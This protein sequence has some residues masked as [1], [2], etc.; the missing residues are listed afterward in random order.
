MSNY[1]DE[2][3]PSLSSLNLNEEVSRCLLCLDAPCSK[4]C[5]A[6]TDPAKFIRSLR[7]KNDKGAI[8]T[9]RL[10]NPLGA[11]C[12]RVCP[13]EK[14]CQAGCSRSGIDKPIDI[15]RIQRYITDEEASLGVKVYQKPAKI[16]E[17]RIAIVG[18]GPAGLTA[19]AMLALDGYQVE[20]F[21]KEEKLGGVLRYG[22]PSYRLPNDVL[23]TEINRILD[24]GVKA[25][26]SIL[27]KKEE[28]EQL[29]KVFNVVVL[30][31]GYSKSKSLD[32]FKD[33]KYVVLAN[34]YLKMIKEANGAFKTPDNV[35]VI[36][37]GDVS[38]DV[39]ASCKLCGSKRVTAVIYEEANE[40]RASPVELNYVR[41]LGAS[42]LDGFVPVE[43]KD[44]NIK[45]KHRF[46]DTKL[47]MSADLIVLAIGQEVN[48]Y[49][50]DLDLR[51]NEINKPNYYLGENVYFAGDISSNE[52]SVVYAV[53]SGKEVAK[54]IER[55]IIINGLN[56]TKLV[57]D[58]IENHPWLNNILG[59]KK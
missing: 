57:D 11:I 37:G 13:T 56:I 16:S 15:G 53:R 41:S 4:A 32:M 34:D 47:E 42:L 3:V 59:G 28:F 18:S 45:F 6:G 12:A 24:L 46:L 49:D 43:V 22:I 55:E 52:K 39:I 29:K 30:C 21:E 36:G 14:Y 51:N 1:L 23:D 48:P 40:F 2:V 10:N 50:L 35:V 38:M 7:F 33:N 19:A 54:Q 20:I 58:V 25:H 8:Y 31:I 9:V 17:R 27:I 5:P 26:T 44:N